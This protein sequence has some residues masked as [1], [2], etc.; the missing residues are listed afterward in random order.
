MLADFLDFF[1]EKGHDGV[2]EGS[3]IL[4][5]GKNVLGLGDIVG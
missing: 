3:C 2:A 1:I 4:V 5:R